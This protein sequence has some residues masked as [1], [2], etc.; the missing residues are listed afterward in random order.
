MRRSLPEF[1][2]VMEI[3]LIRALRHWR[4]LACGYMAVLSETYWMYWNFWR[5]HT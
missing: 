1:N 3:C 4:S 2:C 5:H